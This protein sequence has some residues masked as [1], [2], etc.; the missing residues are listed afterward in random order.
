MS[1]ALGDSVRTVPVEDHV[2]GREGDAG[3]ELEAGAYLSADGIR[4]RP[5][6]DLVVHQQDGLDRDL[7]QV[8]VGEVLGQRHGEAFRIH[9][10]VESNG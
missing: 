6:A 9:V 4:I 2:A 7:L 8:L 1:W 5:A 10:V 3:T